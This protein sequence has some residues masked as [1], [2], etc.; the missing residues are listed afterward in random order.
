[1]TQRVP[2]SRHREVPPHRFQLSDEEAAKFEVNHGSEKRDPEKTILLSVGPDHHVT[3]TMDQLSQLKRL[4]KANGV[5]WEGERHLEA[6]HAATLA[7]ALEEW[8]WVGPVL[9][10]LSKRR[11][12]EVKVRQTNMTHWNERR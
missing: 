11:D 1:M 5:P 6:H 12:V 7:R 10:L 9:A 4:A 8:A 2:S 3:I